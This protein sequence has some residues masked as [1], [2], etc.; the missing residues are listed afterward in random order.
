MN[1]NKYVISDNICAVCMVLVNNQTKGNIE[2]KKFFRA[3]TTGF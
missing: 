2:T 1:N 3:C